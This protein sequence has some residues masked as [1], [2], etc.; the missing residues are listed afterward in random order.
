MDLC[1]RSIKATIMG[2]CL[3]PVMRLFW[4]N[5]QKA[6]ENNFRPAHFCQTLR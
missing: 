3:L 2:H 4:Q 5:F 1:I 6:I